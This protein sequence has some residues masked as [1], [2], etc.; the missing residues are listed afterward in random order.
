MYLVTAS[1]THWVYS[2]TTRIKTHCNLVTAIFLVH[3]IEYIPLQQGLR[4][5]IPNQCIHN[6]LIEYIPLQQGLRRCGVSCPH[7]MTGLIEYIPLQQGLRHSERNCAHTKLSLIEY[8][9]LQQGL[10]HFFHNLLF[11]LLFS[12]SIFHYNKD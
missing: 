5:L 12:L 8:I 4:R 1:C 10:R 2:I 7:I 9:P 3:L 11:C 6:A